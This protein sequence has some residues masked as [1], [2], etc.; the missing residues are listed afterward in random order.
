MSAINTQSFRETTRA[1]TRRLHDQLE[2]VLGLE[3]IVRSEADYKE[4]LQRFYSLWK[5]LE[6]LLLASPLLS[7]TGLDL[8]TR[9]RSDRIVADLD[10]LKSEGELYIAPVSWFEL[11][12]A[13]GAGV[14]YVLEGSTLGGQ[15]I[16][17]RLQED[18][19]IGPET[20]GSFFAAYGD[21]NR[22]M[23]RSFLD[24]AEKSVAPNEISDATEFAVKTFELFVG[25]FRQGNAK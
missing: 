6:D 21:R 9:M 24:W 1:K 4:V 2:E 8:G 16:S 19:G 17:K 3:R 14:L 5:P 13:Q 10:S 23:W 11:D 20:G 25:W 22:E 18:L 15:V 7:E 12:K